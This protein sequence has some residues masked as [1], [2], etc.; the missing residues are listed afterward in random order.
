MPRQAI[1]KEIHSSETPIE[2]KRDVV[3]DPQAHR[4]EGDIVKGNPDALKK[5]YLD[6]LAFMEEAVTI[7]IEPGAEENAPQHVMLCV[8]GRGCEVLLNGKWKSFPGGWIPIGKVLTIKRKYVEVLARSKI[9]RIE[10]IV[11]EPGSAEDKAGSGGRV[12]RF[13]RQSHS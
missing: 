9:D 6:R 11:P 4:D 12:K 5:D 3:K 7:R 1:R 13:T 2:Q 8:N 10:T